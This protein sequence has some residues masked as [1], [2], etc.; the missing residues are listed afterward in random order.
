MLLWP[1]REAPALRH[2]RN[3]FRKNT[4]G[5]PWSMTPR[6]V[7]RSPSSRPAPRLLGHPK[8]SRLPSRCWWQATPRL[9]Y[10][11]SGLY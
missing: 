9:R 10:P 7:L 6:P 3:P 8:R 1:R 11:W 4:K 5:L 2:T